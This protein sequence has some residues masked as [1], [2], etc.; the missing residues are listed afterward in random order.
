MILIMYTP[1]SKIKGMTLSVMYYDKHII[2]LWTI[3]KLTGLAALMGGGFSYANMVLCLVCTM[4]G[5]VA[6]NQEVCEW[7]TA[8]GVWYHVWCAMWCTAHR[9]L[10]LPGGEWCKSDMISS[11]P[12]IPL[13]CWGLTGSDLVKMLPVTKYYPL[14]F[15]IFFHGDYSCTCNTVLYLYQRNR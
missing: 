1:P 8:C 15:G 5:G 13:T 3:R 6:L 9:P 11:P 10:G 12:R 7:W 2:V 14:M 4:P